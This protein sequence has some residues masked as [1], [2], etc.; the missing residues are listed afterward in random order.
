M[1]GYGHRNHVTRGNAHALSLAS[2]ITG[3]LSLIVF[4]IVLGPVAVVTGYLAMNRTRGARG[5]DHTMAVVGLV[6]GAIATVLA[7]VGIA[8]M[9]GNGLYWH[10]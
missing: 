9:S 3:I 1:A 7:I 5:G 2:L 10:M 8:A 4:S 6:L